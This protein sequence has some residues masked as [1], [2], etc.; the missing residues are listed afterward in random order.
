MY[1]SGNQIR[2]S[3]VGALI[4]VGDQPKS[5]VLDLFVLNKVLVLKM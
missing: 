4:H 5:A 3:F 1:C 2:F